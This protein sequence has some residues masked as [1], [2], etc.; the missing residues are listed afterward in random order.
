MTLLLI[1]FALLIPVA[2]D[3]VR[4]GSF[5]RLAIRNVVRRR[6]EAALVILGSMLG[7]A[8]IVASFVVGDTI[9]GSIRDL[10]RTGLGPID[11]SIVLDDP[12]A[13]KALA[14]ELAADPIADT[15]G[16]L[17]L[18]GARAVAA[19][20]QGDDRRGAP[21]VWL[22]EAEFGDIRA[23]G[24]DPGITGFATAG[25]TPS[26]GEAVVGSMLAD[27]LG[28]AAGDT[29]TVFAYGQQ[30]DLEVRQVLD[31]VGV[32][33]WS[34]I[35]LTPGTL[36]ALAA[37]STVPDAQ[38]P[39]GSVVVSNTGGVFDGAVHSDAVMAQLETRTAA[40]SGVE[41]FAEK[42]QLLDD[43]ERDGAEF[44]ELF[45]GIGSFSVVAGIL[46]L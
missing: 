28:V 17:A 31:R 9:G 25:S 4:L 46:L 18:T 2:Y 6:N 40:S 8:I 29:V 32:A 12:A 42:K 13:A 30:L 38:P 45:G 3:L 20:G 24:S 44:T 19:A 35:F 21:V 22:A 15:D 43:A 16:V 34:D 1:V 37:A 5:R 36:E 39:T 23:F 33:G 11:Q 7:T 10:A 26:P 27:D 14:A 41:I